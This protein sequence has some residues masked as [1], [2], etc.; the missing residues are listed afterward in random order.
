MPPAGGGTPFGL[1]SVGEGLRYL[2]GQAVIQAAFLADIDA[3]VFGMPRALFPALGTTLFGGGAAT[4]GLLY[5]A[6]G[7]G[8]L[9][10]AL[11]TG[12]VSAVRRQGLAVIL[13]VAA[14]GAAIALVGITPWLP[15]AVV[16]L[17]VAGAADVVSAVFRGALVQLA[18]PDRLRGRLSAINMTVVAGGPRLGD[19]RAGAVATLGGAQFSVASGGIMCVI[20]TLV[21]ARAYP[22]L[23]RWTID[24]AVNDDE[25]ADVVVTSSEHDALRHDPSDSPRM[26]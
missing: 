5:A 20:G 24:D 3:M 7:I 4:V 10:G 15:L 12:W 16:L 21:L 8:A 11:T 1:R 6:P 9:I 14:W 25:D 18:V 2:K 13:A 26:A 17:A 23:A 19:A 22:Q